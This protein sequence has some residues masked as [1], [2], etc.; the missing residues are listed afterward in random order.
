MVVGAATTAFRRIVLVEEHEVCFPLK[1]ITQPLKWGRPVV[2]PSTGRRPPK[3]YSCAFA[4]TAVHLVGD[5]RNHPLSGNF[6]LETQP[7]LRDFQVNF[8]W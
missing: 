5:F 2:S 7:T 3:H 1:H 4:H 8:A 6:G